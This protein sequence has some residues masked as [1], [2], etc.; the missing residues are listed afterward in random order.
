MEKHIYTKAE[1]QQKMRNIGYLCSYSG[2]DKT[3]YIHGMTKTEVKLQAILFP[4]AFK[5]VAD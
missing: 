5:T 4:T 3:M 2:N 1:F